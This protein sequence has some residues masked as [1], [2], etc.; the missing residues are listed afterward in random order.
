MTLGL[1]LPN[2]FR[3]DSAARM[4]QLLAIAHSAASTLPRCCTNREEVIH[5]LAC[6]Y[7]VGCSWL[8]NTICPPTKY[9]QPIAWQRSPSDRISEHRGRMQLGVLMLLL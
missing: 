6:W 3:L 4:P 2:S 1:I 8:A 9:R 5:S 7:W